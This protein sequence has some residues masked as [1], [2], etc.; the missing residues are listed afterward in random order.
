MASIGY[1]W[2]GWF[3]LPDPD[4]RRQLR[5]SPILRNTSHACLPHLR[6]LFGTR[7]RL[8]ASVVAEAVLREVR[9]TNASAVISISGS[10]QL[11]FVKVAHAITQQLKATDAPAINILPLLGHATLAA[12]AEAALSYSMEDLG[13]ECVAANVKIM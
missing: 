3:H 9:P 4:W 2:G 1:H 10:P 12:V 5:A 8:G 13:E 6:V 11:I 7:P